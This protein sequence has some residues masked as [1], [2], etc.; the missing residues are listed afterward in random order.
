MQNSAYSDL[1]PSRFDTDMHP[2]TQPEIQ[3][4]FEIPAEKLRLVDH[5]DFLT[6]IDWA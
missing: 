6:R 5:G 2:E 3:P 4:A 1:F